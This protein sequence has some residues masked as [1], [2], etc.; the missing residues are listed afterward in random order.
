MDNKVNIALNKAK[1]AGYLDLKEEEVRNAGHYLK[2]Q[3][4]K[5]GL[6]EFPTFIQYD[7][8]YLDITFDLLTSING[9]MKLTTDALMQ[10][11]LHTE[12]KNEDLVA[13]YGQLFKK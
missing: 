5:S 7:K 11:T 3:F 2:F 8:I 4:V 10:G 9:C 6:H 1:G 12:E 13:A